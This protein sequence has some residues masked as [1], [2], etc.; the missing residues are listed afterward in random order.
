[1]SRKIED[2]HLCSFLPLCLLRVLLKQYLS[3]TLKIPRRFAKAVSCVDEYRSFEETSRSDR[4]GSGFQCLPFPFMASKVIEK[5]E[6]RKKK[7]KVNTGIHIPILFK[8][9]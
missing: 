1:M 3:N 2:I 9:I 8:A 6:K 7:G 5:E 4:V